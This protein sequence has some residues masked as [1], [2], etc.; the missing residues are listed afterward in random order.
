MLV[1]ETAERNAGR[2][3]SRASRASLP[4]VMWATGDRWRISS[5]RNW[6]IMVSHRIEIR[7]RIWSRNAPLRDWIGLSLCKSDRVTHMRAT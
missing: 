1:R 7:H 2:W 4:P 6:S 3:S 5:I